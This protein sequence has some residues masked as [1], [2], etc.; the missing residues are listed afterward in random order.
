V[1]AKI[2]DLHV[3]G[4]EG[5]DTREADPSTILGIAEVQGRIGVSEIVLSV[6]SGA[7]EVMR[8]QMAAV[9]GAMKEQ[10]AASVAGC[11]ASGTAEAAVILGIHLEGPFLNAA[12]CGALDPASFLEPQERA[13]RRLVEGFEGIVRIVT[14][15]PEKKGAVE[16]IRMMAAAG[17]AVNMGH[18]N[19]TY[20]EAEAGFRAG[21]RGITHLFN[22]M[23][24]F[25]HREPGIAGF[26]L[27]NSEIYVEVIGD[28][29]HSS[30]HAL[31]LVFRMKAPDR[32]IL[33]SDSVRETKVSQNREPRDEEGRLLGGSLSLPSAMTRL[34][35]AG[36]DAETV[37]RAATEN[38]ERYLRA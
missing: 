2:I 32:I 34:I 38:P 22:G 35:K 33:V 27:V 12:Q 30:P 16:L 1:A 19:A 37:T 9:E 17:I 23:R 14:V 36:F 26:A 31:E 11:G 24:P 25:H 5:S 10:S 3:H 15:A 20:T 8:G 28:L 7:I 6:Y 13:F 4:I 18:S 21:A 29:V